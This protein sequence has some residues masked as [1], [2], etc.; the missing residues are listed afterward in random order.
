MAKTNAEKTIDKIV[1]AA[2]QRMRAG[3]FHGFSFREIAAD[4]GIKSASVHHHFP[5]KEDLA[6]AAVRAYVEREIAVLGDPND[7]KRKPSQL[8]ASYIDLFRSAL[9]DDHAMC[10]C[11]LLASEAATLPPRVTAEVQK[12]FERNLEWTTAV[13]KRANPDMR[14]KDVRAKALMM[15]ATLEG[16]LL[17]SQCQSKLDLF[18]NVARELKASLSL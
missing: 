13:L 9:R 5:T 16:A 12:F 3:G 4:V 18:D 1:K 7:P 15:T 10:L 14:A 2:E 6:V 17:G 11:G 8:V